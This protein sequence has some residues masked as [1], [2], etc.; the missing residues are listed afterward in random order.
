M[1]PSDLMIWVTLMLSYSIWIMKEVGLLRRRPPSPR[2]LLQKAPARSAACRG[3]CAAPYA[4]RAM[5]AAKF[6]QTLL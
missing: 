2:F 5:R 1:T 4:G 3:P 6:A